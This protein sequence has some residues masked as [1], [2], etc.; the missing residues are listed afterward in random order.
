MTHKRI[1][2]LGPDMADAAVTRRVQGLRGAGATVIAYAFKRS[3]GSAIDVQSLGT[4]ADGNMRKRLSAMRLAYQ[5]LSKD[6][7]LRDIDA[8]YARN[9]DVALLALALRRRIGLSVPIVY[10][11]L[12]LHPLLERTG[13]IGV[14][15]RALERFVLRRIALLVVSSPAFLDRYF[16][17]VQGYHAQGFLLEN[18]V[19]GITQE[20]RTAL[21]QPDTPKD[22]PF[23]IVFAGKLRC[24]KSLHILT[25]LAAKAEDQLCVRLAGTVPDS[26]KTAYDALAAYPNVQVSG[27]YDYPH[28]LKDIYRDADL[29][30]TLDYSSAQN[31]EL[32]IPNRLYEG[33]LFG[34]PPLLRPK[35]ATAARAA[36]WGV[37]MLLDDEILQK[38]AQ[39][40]RSL[41]T[42]LLAHRQRLG[43]CAADGFLAAEDHKRL[44]AAF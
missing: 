34:V 13:P 10:E 17:P 11:V 21:Y 36:Q 42:K 38:L 35:T 39:N 16:A 8:I 26:L 19:E 27:A 22:A 6:H 3:V 1:L 28:D 9:L 29:N 41:R 31:A 4:A 5:K 7:A 14:V 18:K 12:D 24:E 43:V 30:W 2:Y 44:L 15:A 40:P 25:D 23:T 33:G 32:L 37:G 20:A